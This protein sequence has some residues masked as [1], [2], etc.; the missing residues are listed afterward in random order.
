MAKDLQRFEIFNKHVYFI[1]ILLF[2]EA[3]GDLLFRI[4]K[5]R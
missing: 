4:L 3:S 1:F 2:Q 5:K